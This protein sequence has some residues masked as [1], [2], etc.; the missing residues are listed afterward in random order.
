MCIV[1]PDSGS[2]VHFTIV[3][4]FRMRMRLFSFRG[5]VDSE[6]DF[7]VKPVSVVRAS[8]GVKVALVG[9]SR[10]NPVSVVRVREGV[11][12]ALVGVS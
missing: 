9:V 10:V 2:G 7:R 1:H 8:E 4:D 5:L 11:K 6:D 12:A 3:E